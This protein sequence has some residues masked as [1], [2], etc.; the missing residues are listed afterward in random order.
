MIE[1]VTNVSYMLGDDTLATLEVDEGIAYVKANNKR[2]IGNVIL[3]AEIDNNFIEKS[4]SITSL[5]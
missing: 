5:W 1:N 2:K 3:L 4:I